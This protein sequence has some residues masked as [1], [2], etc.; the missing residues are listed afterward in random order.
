MVKAALASGDARPLRRFFLIQVASTALVFGLLSLFAWLGVWR[1]PWPISWLKPLNLMVLALL[2]GGVSALLARI[3]RAPVWWLWIHAMFMVGIV[4]A[5][6]LAFPPEFWLACF[7]VVLL[8]FWRTDT[9]QIPLYLTNQPSRQAV[10]SLLPQTPCKVMDIGCGDGAL[11]RHLARARP[12]C[13]LVGIEHAPLT[14]AWAWLQAQSIANLSIVRGDFWTYPFH[15]CQVVYA[16]LSPAPMSRLGVKMHAEMLP[17]SCL[18]SNSFAISELAPVTIVDV[19]DR[20]RTKLYLYRP[21]E[22]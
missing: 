9:G 19:S 22:N 5:H 11:L 6:R 2:Q 10:L 14:W 3:L 1:E 21:G 8:V 20:R 18:I 15:D 12:D 16:F 4:L 13:L 17:G 7:L